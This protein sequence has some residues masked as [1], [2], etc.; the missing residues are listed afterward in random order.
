MWKP[1]P[2]PF[3]NF[4]KDINAK[5]ASVADIIYQLG[6]YEALRKPSREIA[7]DAIQSEVMQG[8]F[9]Y[10]K[11]CLIEYRE[12]TGY[13]RGIAGV[14]IG[15][16]ERFCVV[17]TPLQLMLII[18][19]VITKKSAKVLL[20]PEMCM[21][22]FPIIAPVVRPAWIEFEYVDEKGK[23]Q[24]WNTKDTT[25]KG[26]ILNRVFQHEIDHMSGIM[27]ID[28]VRSPKELLL[29][30]YPSFYKNATFTEID[31]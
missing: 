21:S 23:K 16:P 1:T 28:I 17:Y 3:I 6:E 9:N 12:R 25:A 5:A 15:E 8:K 7:L 19:P 13:G 22:A 26:R 11:Q 24:V 31:N 30:S 10:I 27:N 20:Y 4:K 14:Q 2:P 29:Y 18:N